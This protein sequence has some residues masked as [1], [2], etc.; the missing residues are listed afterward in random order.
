M[1]LK[2]KGFWEEKRLWG[3]GKVFL[4]VLGK[5]EEKFLGKIKVSLLVLREKEEQKNHFFFTDMS[6]CLES[7]LTDSNDK[8]TDSNHFAVSNI[9]L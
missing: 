6:S 5:K 9:R 8:L 3:R 7:E 2:R 4:L 1:K